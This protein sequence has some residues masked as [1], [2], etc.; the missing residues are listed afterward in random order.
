MSNKV[1]RI[2]VLFVS[3]SSSACNIFQSVLNGHADSLGRIIS[4]S[5]LLLDE[6]LKILVHMTT[7]GFD[8]KAVVFKSEKLADCCGIINSLRD[9][10]CRAAIAVVGSTTAA[11]DALDMIGAGADHY[12]PPSSGPQLIKAALNASFRTRRF[13]IDDACDALA[14]F[15]G[16]PAEA[17]RHAAA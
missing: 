9:K 13:G 1:P 2:N 11:S 16:K 7:R 5:T 3:N 15:A 12:L 10:G 6:H 14:A 8:Y 17:E 4:V